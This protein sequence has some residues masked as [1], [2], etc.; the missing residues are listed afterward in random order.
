MRFDEIQRGPG[1]RSL[2]IIYKYSIC[3]TTSGVFIFL[4][5]FLLIFHRRTSAKSSFSLRWF[6]STLKWISVDFHALTVSVL[7]LNSAYV[8]NENWNMQNKQS[9]FLRNSVECVRNGSKYCGVV[10]IW[11]SSWIAIFQYIW[12]TPHFT[13]WYE[14]LGLNRGDFEVC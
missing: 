12:P 3:K 2:Y 6:K 1:V 8:F 13:I 11:T 10:K 9:I 4:H 14:G 7:N 5:L